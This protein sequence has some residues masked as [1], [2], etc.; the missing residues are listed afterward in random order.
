VYAAFAEPARL[1][2]WLPPGCMTGRVT[3]YDFRV[4]GHYEIELTPRDAGEITSGKTTTQR[5]VSRGR[6]VALAPGER[7]V[8]TVELASADPA[9]RGEMIM[10]WSFAPSSV[11]TT[12]TVTT[13]NVPPGI[14]Q[15]DHD[16][17]LHS[18][19]RHLAKYVASDSPDPR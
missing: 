9:F 13:A 5:D 16:E 3:E 15:A 18:S 2:Q 7:I 12:V 4:G 6:F 14:A 19:L 17:G 8:Q 10:T 1:L 11:G